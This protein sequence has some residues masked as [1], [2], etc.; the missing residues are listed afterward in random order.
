MGKVVLKGYWVLGYYVG[1]SGFES[2]NQFTVSLF[3]DIHHYYIV[4]ITFLLIDE[5]VKDKIR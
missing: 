2:L 1:E 4:K 5:Q 3:G